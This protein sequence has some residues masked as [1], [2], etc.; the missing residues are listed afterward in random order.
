MNAGRLRIRWLCGLAAATLAAPVAHAQ[1]TPTPSPSP[2][3]IITPQSRPQQM[4]GVI[5]ERFSIGPAPSAT[6][7]PTPTPTA[8]AAVPA[9]QRP[10]PVARA[11]P[12]PRET[13][14]PAAA[15][16]PAASSTP[17]PVPTATPLAAPTPLATIAPQPVATAAP[18]PAPASDTSP[19]LWAAAGAGGTALLGLGGWLLF[20][21]RRPEEEEAETVF[22]SEPVAAAPPPPVQ[23]PPGLARP[24]PAPAPAPTP[25]R[26]AAPVP[27]GND[28]FEL[29][30]NPHRVL[31]GENEMVLEFELLIANV[32]GASAEN[33]RIAF[34]AMSAHARQDE[35][36]A[37]FHGG[38]PGEPGGAP[39]DLTPGGGGRMPVRLAIPASGVQVVQVGGRPMFVPIVLIDLRWRGGL[40]IRRFGADFMLGTVGQGDKL[41][42]FW[43]DRPAPTGPLAANRY[44]AKT[45]VAA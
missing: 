27:R 20:G 18:A 34:A 8:S 37:G 2:A 21:R 35:V 42:P 32:S 43:L 19:W 28:P 7:A 12:A 41:G 44:F 9:S 17:A 36:I 30:L 29:A 5:P 23:P 33:I 10:A 31:Y 14:R 3:P 22:E 11:T 40:S 38:P 24:T 13:A 15:P 1:D 16:T 4:P 25:V 26:A 45:A 39:F 6:P